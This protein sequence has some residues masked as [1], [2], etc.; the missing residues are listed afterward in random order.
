MNEEILLLHFVG[1]CDSFDATSKACQD[2]GALKM[3]QFYDLHAFIVKLLSFV[4]WT[5]AGVTHSVTNLVHMQSKFIISAFV[6]VYNTVTYI[7][8][9]WMR[10]VVINYS[11]TQNTYYQME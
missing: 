8:L 3:H 4:L 6:S 2:F 10:S 11:K 7:T 5:K 1:T 9:S